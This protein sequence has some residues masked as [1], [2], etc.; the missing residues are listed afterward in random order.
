M[1]KFTSDE[2]YIF[3][4]AYSLEFK[5]LWSQ[6]KNW[7]ADMKTQNIT[8]FKI[9]I[10]IIHKEKNVNKLKITW[11]NSPVKS[12]SFKNKIIKYTLC[13]TLSLSCDI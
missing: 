3:Y 11:K 2:T 9:R 13:N 7:K 12:G 10:N 4:K 5:P 1:K 8:Q 6:V